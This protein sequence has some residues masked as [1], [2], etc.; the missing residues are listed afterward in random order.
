[1]TCEKGLREL[2]QS[3]KKKDTEAEHDSHTLPHKRCV[4]VNSVCKNRKVKI[5][6]PLL[7][8]RLEKKK[9]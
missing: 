4:K 7:W 3:R 2:I 5:L 9:A 1:M 6:Y 8:E